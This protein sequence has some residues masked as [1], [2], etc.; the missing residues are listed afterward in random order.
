MVAVHARSWCSALHAN[1]IKVCAWQYVYGNAPVTEAY[2]GAAA[3]HDGADCLIIDAESEYE[4]KY[5][6]A[7]TYIKRL[8]S[9]IGYSYP[10]ALAGFPYIDFHPAFPYS[11]FLGPRRRPVQRAADVLARHRH[12]HRQRLRPHL[13]L[14][15]HLPAARS[16]RWA[17]STADR[18]PTRWCASASSPASTAPRA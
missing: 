17:R 2:K 11:V 9:L 1:G 10:L 5:V 16:I 4:G 7:Q 3:V 13:R 14:Q 6:S 12:H 15:P 18:R 8:R